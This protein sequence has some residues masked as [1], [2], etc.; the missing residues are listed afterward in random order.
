MLTYSHFSNKKTTNVR[1]I[2]D[3]SAFIGI[4]IGEPLPGI[5][6]HDIVYIDTDITAK[7]NKPVKRKIFIWK[8]ADAKEQVE[9]AMKLNADFKK[10]FNLDSPITVMWEFIKTSLLTILEQ[11]VPS[12]M[13]SSRFNQPWINQKIKKLTR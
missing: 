5:G 6:D 8:K 1:P 2:S 4:S 7:I 12:K 3:N 11:T 10:K 9:K 13:S